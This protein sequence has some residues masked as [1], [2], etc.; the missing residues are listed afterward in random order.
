ML[1]FKFTPYALRWQ[2]CF[3]RCTFHHSRSPTPFITTQSTVQSP[4]YLL[5][6]WHAPLHLCEL[7]YLRLSS[8][9]YFLYLFFGCTHSMQKFRGQESNP[10]HSSD[11]SHSSDSARSLTHWATGELPHPFLAWVSCVACDALLI[12]Y[13]QASTAAYLLVLF[14]PF[15]PSL[16]SLCPCHFHIQWVLIFW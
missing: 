13:L 2:A 7:S 6:P 15:Y 8:S 4:N 10:A 3:F 9:P 16:F 12:S 14:W 5:F 11:L 1:T